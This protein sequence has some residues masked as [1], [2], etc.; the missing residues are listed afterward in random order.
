MPAI[1]RSNLMGNESLMGWQYYGSL[2][3]TYGIYPAFDWEVNN[4]PCP[5]TYRPTLR[6]W[7]VAGATGQ[8]D[9]II[10][11]DHSRA[12]QNAVDGFQGRVAQAQAILDTLSFR[13]F[14]GIIVYSTG[15][16]LYDPLLVQGTSANVRQLKLYLSTLA[17]SDSSDP[18][19]GAALTQ[20]YSMFSASA[21]AGASSI[22]NK[23]IVLLT[24]GVNAIN[25][26]NVLDVAEQ[27]SEDIPLVI[28]VHDP[29]NSNPPVKTSRELSCASGGYTLD[30][31]EM[32]T[33]AVLE[34]LTVFLS[35]GISE[36]NVRWSEVYLDAFGLGNM[37][38]AALPVTVRKGSLLQLVGMMAVDVKLAGLDP[39]G[40]IPI[41]DINAY[42]LSDQ[43]CE[44]FTIPDDVA[45]NINR[46]D[47]CAELAAE[48]RSRAPAAERNR[49]SIVA[50]SVICGYL[51]AIACAI[52]CKIRKP[53]FEPFK[54][55]RKT[56]DRLFIAFIVAMVLL[57]PW[58]F[59]VLFDRMWD[60]IIRF[61]Y[62]KRSELVT[63]G[64]AVLEFRCCDITNC[65]CAS[66][67]GE[68]CSA[69]RN[70][71]LDNPGAGDSTPCNNGY[72]CCRQDS[73]QC[74]CRQSCS[75]SGS[76]RSCRRTCD[77]C[78]RCVQSVNNRRCD[79][80]CGTCRRITYDASFDNSQTGIRSFVQ[81][82][83]NCGRDDLNCVDAN[84]QR[85]MPIG[86][87]QTIYFNPADPSEFTT[88]KDYDS[89][90]M[91]ALLIPGIILAIIVLIFLLS[92][93]YI[94]RQKANESGGCDCCLNACDLCC[95]DMKPKPTTSGK[96]DGPSSEPAAAA[97]L[98]AAEADG[99]MAEHAH[100]NPVA[101]PSNT[102]L[103][104]ATIQVQ[105]VQDGPPPAY[106]SS[107]YDQAAFPY[108][109]SDGQAYPPPQVDHKMSMVT[110][111]SVA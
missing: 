18:N 99:N 38:T 56:G 44:R 60:P 76:N 81:V 39:S 5:G 61:T 42:L 46:R 93:L 27:A 62:W 96:P 109:T 70:R 32:A 15:S 24:S 29:D 79:V 47:K 83:E 94:W 111:E 103:Y 78:H 28:W 101:P 88:D 13:D 45:E 16:E 97:T 17:L 74:N 53:N 95:G 7:F 8:K 50:A 33:F 58:F 20:A 11:L 102:E 2:N 22:C 106:S 91:A 57:M 1:W 36:P 59:G 30:T 9:M 100:L 65:R 98:T 10:L 67:N 107:P 92:L 54:R 66:F 77:T 69:A 25:T 110:H 86:T 12:G 63:E 84:D 37:T 31:S 4:E 80:V 75:G 34:T 108:Y 21:Q 6:P 41:A 72:F 73:Y 87:K 19:M 35:S 85:F 26:P 55:L 105:P 104:P 64:R 3:D 82:I 40:T 71:L 52:V 48:R 14:V 68:S 23:L 89:G 90:D 51:F 49:S 43:A